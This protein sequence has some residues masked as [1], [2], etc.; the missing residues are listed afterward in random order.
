MKHL[1]L[2]PVLFFVLSATAQ[3]TKISASTKDH[4]PR[5]TRFGF[6]AGFN[7]SNVKGKETDGD[8]TG[9]IG[10]EVYAGFFT[11]IMVGKQFNIGSECLF[12]WTDDYHFVEVPVHLQFSFARNWSVFAGPKL[13]FLLDSSDEFY[14][15]KNFGISA[16]MGVQY[17][18]LRNLFAEIRQSIGFTEQITDVALDIN[19]AKRNTSRIGLGIRF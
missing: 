5:T 1:F 10:G 7:R 11:E 16:D 9:Y 14:R 2:F 3:D 18:I 12:S 13:D 4:K 8:K 19:N 15:F 17:N 6:K